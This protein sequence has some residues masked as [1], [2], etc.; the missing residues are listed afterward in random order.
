MMKTLH[1]LRICGVVQ[2]AGHRVAGR[3]ITEL[4]GA[5]NPV[6]A[7]SEVHDAACEAD[8]ARRVP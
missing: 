4:D 8:A 2:V 5:N 7:L 3:V 1:C 6:S